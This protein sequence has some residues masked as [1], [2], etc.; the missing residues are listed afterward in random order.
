MKII[1][2]HLRGL[3]KAP[4]S[5][6][7]CFTSSQDYKNQK[8]KKKRE[9]ELTEPLSTLHPTVFK[10]PAEL[11]RLSRERVSNKLQHQYIKV[12]RKPDRKSLDAEEVEKK[13]PIV[14]PIIEE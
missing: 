8:R 4:L 11:N 9:E 7:E 14:R 1:K 12:V 10:L 13:E 2:P 3:E 6:K 5:E